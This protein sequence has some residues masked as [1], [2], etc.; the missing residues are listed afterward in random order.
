MKWLIARRQLA[1]TIRQNVTV[2]DNFSFGKNSV[3]WA[4]RQ[5]TIGRNVSL[6]S[7]VRVEIDGKIGDG[8][9]IANSAG[10]VGRQDHD[11]T[12]VGVSIRDSRWVGRFPGDLSR[13][14]LIGSDVWIGYAATVLSGVTVGDSC[15][16]GAGSV[17]T[18]SIPSNS[19]AVGNPARVIG[20]RFDAAAFE[21]HWR[22]L[23][24]L[25]F[26]RISE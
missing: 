25:G 20:T 4:P 3:V 8:V 5:L 19:I 16:I 11:M 7:N 6:G 22:K 13:T 14:T 17:V 12:Q 9:L 26:V 24:D 21:L 2:G 23:E 18:T 10:I 15:V 1:A